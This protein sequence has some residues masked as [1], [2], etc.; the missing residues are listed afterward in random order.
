MSQTDLVSLDR[1]KAAYG[2]DIPAGSETESVYTVLISAASRACLRYLGRDI[3]LRE[4][5]QF[6][7]GNG[8]DRFVL[9]E[10]PVVS[11]TSL[12]I[13]RERVFATALDPVAYR[14]DGPTGIVTLY[15]GVVLPDVLDCVK[16]VYQAGYVTIPEDIEAA[17][18]DTIQMMK[19]RLAGSSAGVS[20]RSMPDGGTET[21]ETTAP[22]DF[23]K[24][25][26][27]QYRRGMAR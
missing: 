12:S 20:S 16:V 7:D 3:H 4:V 1:L 14:V 6:I 10:A 26:L 9:D 19:R 23:A 15:Q 8:H 21:L 11:I 2:L 18:V 17:C 25:L 13:D 5:T 24:L 27:G 22:T